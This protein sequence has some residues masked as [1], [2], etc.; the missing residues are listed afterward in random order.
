MR[1][2]ILSC[3]A[4]KRTD[5]GLLPALARYDGP[6][7]RVLRK[8]LRELAQDVHPLVAILSAEFGLI[9][10]DT[11]IPWYDRRM[12]ATRAA[13]LAPLVK[14]KLQALLAAGPTDVFIHL[15]R[16]Y[17]PTLGTVPPGPWHICY[18]Q[19]GIGERLGQLR[20]WLSAPQQEEVS[21]A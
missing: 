12:D 6:A 19:G 17:L 16:D 5:P 21:H 8:A 4:T 2:L 1:L 9:D 7:Y 14:R 20:R 11:P 10:S 15:G 13:A 18:A 3:S